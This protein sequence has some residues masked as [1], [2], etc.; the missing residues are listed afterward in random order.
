VP[1]YRAHRRFIGPCW[2]FRYP[3]QKALY[4]PDSSNLKKQDGMMKS[5]LDVL[6]VSISDEKPV[7]RHFL[8]SY[9]FLHPG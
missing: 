3:D 8:N 9:D 6:R 2:L 5:C 4:V 1:I 7:P